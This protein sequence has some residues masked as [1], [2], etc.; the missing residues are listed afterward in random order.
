VTESLWAVRASDLLSRTA[1]S[2]PTPGGGSIAA[3]TGALGVGLMQMAVAV[4][5]DDGLDHL[6]ARLDEL[7]SRVVPAADSDVQDFEAV[8]SAYRLPRD[9][10]A[11][12]AERQHAIEAATV[13]ATE[14]PLDLVAALVDALELSHELEPV[15]KRGIVSDV[16]AGRDLV[17]GSARA[18]IRTADINLGQ[19]DRLGS[20]RGPALRERRD[21]LV[22]RLEEAA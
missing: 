20:D 19:L 9:D 13:G 18:A 7:Q 15:V 14:R 3:V 1:S 5:A 17:V 10:D 8:M 22:Q 21:A 4:T 16:L 2:D 12:R 6:A 11:A